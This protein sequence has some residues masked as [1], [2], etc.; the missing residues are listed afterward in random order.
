M[1]FNHPKARHARKVQNRVDR[2]SIRRL[3]NIQPPEKP[4]EIFQSHLDKTALG[5]DNS[6]TLS[7]VAGWSDLCL[8]SITYECGHQS[9]CKK[10]LSIL[11]GKLQTRALSERIIIS[12]TLAKAEESTQ[13]TTL[14]RIYEIAIASHFVLHQSGFDRIIIFVKSALSFR[15]LVFGHGFFAVIDFSCAN[16]RSAGSLKCF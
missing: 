15:L 7:C 11:L 14:K 5:V 3:S 12:S 10:S 16:D 8:R 4:N 13:D 9:N 6:R 1:P 2:Q